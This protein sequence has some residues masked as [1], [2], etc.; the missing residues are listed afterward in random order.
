M[1]CRRDNPDKNKIWICIG[2]RDNETKL[3]L[4]TV[5][6]VRHPMTS[7]L[8]I[9]LPF[10]YDSS[11]VQHLLNI[12]AASRFHWRLV[13]SHVLSGREKAPLRLEEL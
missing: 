8:R 5:D 11:L 12:L 6:T 1:T 10:D 2:N 3:L 4:E 13:F 7:G 9:I